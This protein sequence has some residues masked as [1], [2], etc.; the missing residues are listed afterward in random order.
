MVG[1]CPSIAPSVPGVPVLLVAVLLPVVGLLVVLLAVPVVVGHLVV[2]LAVPVV[3]GRLG[4]I[5]SQPI[6][7]AVLYDFTTY[8]YLSL[9]TTV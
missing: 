1:D 4:V 6:N 8:Y 2:L 7:G 9:L 5:P 3:V